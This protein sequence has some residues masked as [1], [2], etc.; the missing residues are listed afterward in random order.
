MDNKV[1]KKYYYGNIV[2]CD[3]RI[4]NALGK[5]LRPSKDGKVVI[6]ID[7]K[8]HIRLIST[9]MYEAVNECSA[10]K[11]I[12]SWKSPGNYSYD[13]LIIK[14][15][16]ELNRSGE[17]NNGRQVLTKKDCEQIIRERNVPYVLY[18]KNGKKRINPQ[19]PYHVLAKKY[20]CSSSTVQK[21]LLGR[22]RVIQTVEHKKK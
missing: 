19:T 6:Y 20:G 13:N 11:K 2:Y 3:G 21:V 18:D 1:E 12:L 9:I 17:L 4:F 14:D 10:R 22:Y 15:R 5:E 7:G 16:G 8:R